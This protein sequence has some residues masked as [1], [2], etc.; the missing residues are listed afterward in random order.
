[1][2]LSPAYRIINTDVEGRYRITKDV[3]TDPGRQTLFMRVA[4]QAFED[5]VTPYLLVNPHMENT[6]NQDV[7]FTGAAHL[8]ARNVSDNR[9]MIV[10]SSSGFVKT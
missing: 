1:R 3:Y 6:G 5:G 7:G 9:Y 2:P 4:F 8:G 10:R